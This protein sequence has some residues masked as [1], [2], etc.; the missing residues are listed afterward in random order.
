MAW[1]PAEPVYRA[2]ANN[3]QDFGYSGVTGEMIG[4]IRRAMDNDE[5]LP[6]GVIGMFARDQIEKAKEQG[7][8]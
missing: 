5:E 6:H 2:I 4:E 1:R 3:L 7:F 8:L